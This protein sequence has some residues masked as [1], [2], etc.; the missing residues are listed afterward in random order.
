MPQNENAGN[1][2]RF[3]FLD[4][5]DSWGLR[6]AGSTFAATAAFAFSSVF[7]KQCIDDVNECKPDN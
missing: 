7:A 3:L 4:Y 5:F 1:C 6:F 2:R